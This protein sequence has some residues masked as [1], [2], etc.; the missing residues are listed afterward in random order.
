MKKMTFIALAI[1]AIGAAACSGNQVKYNISGVNAPEDGK[2]VYLIDQI[3]EAR[4][5]SAV[6]EA[7][8]F[9]TRVKKIAVS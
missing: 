6:V 3:S 7:G 5:D 8:G 4:I 1:A 9:R 2:T